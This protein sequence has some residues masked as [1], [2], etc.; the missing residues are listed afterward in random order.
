MTRAASAATSLD[1][2]DGIGPSL[3]ELAGKPRRITADGQT[4]EI[5]IDEEYLKRAIREPEAELVE[6]Y[7]PMMPAYDTETISQEDLQAVVDYLLGKA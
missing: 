3:F 4:I 7:D 1:G 6:G 2:S 5:T